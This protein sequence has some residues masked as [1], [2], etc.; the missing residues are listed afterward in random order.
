MNGAEILSRTLVY[1]AGAVVA[2]PI[3]KRLGLGSVLGYIVAGAVIGPGALSLIGD[4]TEVGHFAEFGVVML[5]FLIGLEMRPA[6]L[7]QMRNAIFG[8]GGG[9]MISATLLMAPLGWALG[10]PLA[11][12]TAVSLILAMSSTALVLST[13]E[14]K[15]QRTQPVGKA[16]FGVLLLQDLSVIPLFLLLPMLGAGEGPHPSASGGPA[17]WIRT[18][19]ILLALAIVFAGGRFAVRPLFRFI[20]STRSREV[21]TAGA[22]LLVVGVAVLMTAVGL[23]PA[24]GAFTAGVIL[25]ETEFRQELESD[26]EPFRGLLLGLFFMAV[27]GGLDLHLLRH[28]FA[29]I[30]GI[31]VGMMIAKTVS[32]YGAARLFRYR[33][34]EAGAIAVALCQGGEFAFVLITFTKSQGILPAHL[35]GI[36]PPVIAISMLLSSIPGMLYDRWFMRSTT[37]ADHGSERTPFAEDP[38][39]I[40]AGFGRFGQIA[41]RLL[42][43]NGH[44]LSIM[45]AD[46]GHIELLRR[47]GRLVSF[48]DATRLDLLRAAGAEKAK[49]LIVAI[50]DRE[51]AVKLVEMARGSFPN[52]T[53]L[54]RAWDR[55]HAWELL[56]AG[57][58]HVESETYESSLQL[59]RHAL[60]SLGHRA[61]RAHRAASLFRMHDRALFMQNRPHNFDDHG[62][63]NASRAARLSLE[64]LLA[65]DIERDLEWRGADE[66]WGTRSLYDDLTGKCGGH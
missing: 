9:Q 56:E 63:L 59:G 52:L 60:V 37:A 29:V 7:W 28:E 53:I 49:L 44:R 36:L 55:R 14:E 48:G 16:C 64:E 12:S 8:L 39:V 17:P 22:L 23:S 50:D 42:Q 57:A 62:F 20:A 5:M 66:E 34:R 2:V 4:P 54:A 35:A 25:A 26:I 15:G 47:F 24:L 46:L 21:F 18:G 10:L 65:A 19:E 45:D 61:H 31:A 33:P 6:L 30:F 41:G 40:V 51:N 27:G 11:T 3:A 43:A 13:L 1:L 32:M 58:D 38:D